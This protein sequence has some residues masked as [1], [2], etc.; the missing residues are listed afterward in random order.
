MFS[1]PGAWF[2]CFKKGFFSIYCSKIKPFKF[3]PRSHGE[4]WFI[5]TKQMV[6]ENPGARITVPGPLL[7]R[8][9]ALGIELVMHHF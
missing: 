1:V 2:L 5:N 9:E 8:W 6:L 3:L 7:A 4:I